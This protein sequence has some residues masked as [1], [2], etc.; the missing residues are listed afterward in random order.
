M[1]NAYYEYIH[2]KPLL[3]VPFDYT[4]DKLPP[5]TPGEFNICIF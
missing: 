2:V 5:A 3:I 4:E 1:Q